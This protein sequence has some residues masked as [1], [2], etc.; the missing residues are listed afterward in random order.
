MHY[1]VR[2]DDDRTLELEIGVDGPS[3]AGTPLDAELTPGGA[4]VWLLRLGTRVHR[5]VAH[6][7]EGQG[8]WDLLI[9]GAAVRAEA[10]DARARHLRE[11]TTALA[12]AV[13]P[14]P[15]VAPM[16]GLVVRIE[17]AVGD[18]VE[19]GE[20]IAIVEAMKMENELVASGPGRVTAI[21]AT[22]GKAVEKGE[23]LVEF[24][25][26]DEATDEDPDEETS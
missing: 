21:P 16:P 5:V 2:L 12:G 23:V 25:P 9:D 1:F 15:V 18:L 14:K 22:V 20:G 13:G 3:V 8:R 10:L 24:E 6:R 11:M 17:V 26:V 4:G 7:A 19:E